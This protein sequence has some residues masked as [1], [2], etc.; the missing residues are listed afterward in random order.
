MCESKAEGGLRCAAHTRPPYYAALN[1]LNLIKPGEDPAPVLQKVFTAAVD[2][3]STPTGQTEVL[4]HVK[5]ARPWLAE[6]LSDAANRGHVK[7]TAHHMANLAARNRQTMNSR[8]PQTH[9]TPGGWKLS[10]HVLDQAALKGIKLEALMACVDNPTVAYESGRYPG[11]KK[12]IRDGLCVAV[13]VS[14]KT[15]I[16]VFL[17]R[18]YTDVRDDQ[19]DADARK[20]A[21]KKAQGKLN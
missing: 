21:E 8:L 19:T 9:I 3:A 7:L 11:Q 5:K 12:H 20:Y 15:A 13:D 14:S 2:Y 10:R 17:D 18:V 4:E 6:I 1:E 16:T